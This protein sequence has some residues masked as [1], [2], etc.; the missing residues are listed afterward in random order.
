MIEERTDTVDFTTGDVTLILSESKQVSMES[1]S[2]EVFYDAQ[3]RVKLN[4]EEIEADEKEKAKVNQLI[5]P[6]GKSTFLTLSDGTRVWINSGSRMIYPSVFEKKKREIYIAGEAYFD[7]VKNEDC[8]FIIKTN[9]IDVTVRGTKL[10]VSAYDNDPSQ[11]VVLVSGKVDVKGREEKGS[12]KMEPNQM[13]SYDVLSRE[14]GVKNVDVS[15]YT[16]WIEGYLLVHHESI[17]K[18]LDK[19]DRHYNTKSHY[20]IKD[21]KNIYVSGKL[22]MKKDI[23]KVLEYL[24]TTAPIVYHIEGRNIIIKLKK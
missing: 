7:V 24:S 6:Y 22:D 1:D 18:L 3:G 11:T 9:E 8:P 4:S 21:F 12:Y 14:V 20:D 2:A 23:E 16:S 17:D 19:I 10:N 15:N 13:F 5:V